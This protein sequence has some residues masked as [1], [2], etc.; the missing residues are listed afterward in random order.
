MA[1][2]EVPLDVPIELVDKMK[3]LRHEF[4]DFFDIAK[5]VEVKWVIDSDVIIFE[6]TRGEG[7]H[8]VIK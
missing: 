4:P 3:A 2:K 8:T 1:D 7:S 5:Y 6:M